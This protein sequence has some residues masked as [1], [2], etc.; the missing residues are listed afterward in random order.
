VVRD[1]TTTVTN[2]S[3]IFHFLCYSCTGTICVVRDSTTTVTNASDIFH[4][5][6]YSKGVMASP[7]V[8]APRRAFNPSSVMYVN[9]LIHCLIQTSNRE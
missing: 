9:F 8:Q 5:L 7:P 6:C 1:S 2:A 3:D 4:F